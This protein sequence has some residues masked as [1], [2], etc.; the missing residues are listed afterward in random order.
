MT[1]HLSELK[2]YGLEYQHRANSVGS[3]TK[4]AILPIVGELPESGLLRR[5]PPGARLIEADK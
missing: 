3:L 5:M 2:Y 1:T 4:R